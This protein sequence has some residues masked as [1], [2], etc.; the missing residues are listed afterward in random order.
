MWEKTLH[1]LL[2]FLLLSV[3]N[4]FELNILISNLVF[5]KYRHNQREIIFLW[6]ENYLKKENNFINDKK[7]FPLDSRVRILWRLN[8]TEFV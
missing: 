5:I 3:V 2:T 8:A 7:Y 1:L 4:L 6:S